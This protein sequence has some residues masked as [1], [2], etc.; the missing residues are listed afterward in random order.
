MFSNFLGS[1]QAGL[2]VVTFSF[3][4]DGAS[5][6]SVILDPGACVTSVTEAT[7]RVTVTLDQ[8][9]RITQLVGSSVD[10]STIANK[11]CVFSYDADTGVVLV[12][13]GVDDAACVAEQTTGVVVRVT[14]IGQ[15]IAELNS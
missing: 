7:G 9:N 6:P 11:G 10:C 8:T 12:D 1:T 14:L 3:T 5:D 13:V 15:K 4:T 2:H